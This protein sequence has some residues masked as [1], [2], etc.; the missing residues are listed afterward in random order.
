[1][2]R[3]AAPPVQHSPNRTHYT[4]TH[5]PTTLS[6]RQPLIQPKKN[7]NNAA[8]K[9]QTTTPSTLSP[10]QSSQTLAAIRQAAAASRNVVRTI[11]YN[12]A[13]G[14]AFSVWNQAVMQ[15]LLFVLGGS[16]FVVG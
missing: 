4:N 11:A 13:D 1:M 15:Q 2:P 9:T 14:A 6:E 3:H 12:L 7:T 10:I 8:T 16:N 5:T